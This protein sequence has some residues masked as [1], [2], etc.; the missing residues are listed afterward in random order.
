MFC[1]QNNHLA[2]WWWL[3]LKLFYL[4]AF[5]VKW[6]FWTESED[7][8]YGQLVY[9]H[10]LW[11]GPKFSLIST[12]ADSSLVWHARWDG[13]GGST[14]SQTARRPSQTPS[15]P[16]VPWQGQWCIHQ[17]TLTPVSARHHSGHYVC[18][19]D[20]GFTATPV[21]KEVRLEVHRKYFLQTSPRSSWA[22]PPDR[23]ATR[24]H[25]D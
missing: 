3:F 25:S 17:F 9:L 7:R 23:R 13:E 19:A 8:N 22:P 2:L 4:I 16:S 14:S 18:E 1:N 5:S 6:T 21:S 24:G 20:N 10:F 11:F 15:W 12:L